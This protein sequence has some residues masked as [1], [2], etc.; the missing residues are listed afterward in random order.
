MLDE[1]EKAPLAGGAFSELPLHDGAGNSEIKPPRQN[2]QINQDPAPAEF[3]VEI[4]LALAASH[5]RTAAFFS[6]SHCQIRGGGRLSR[7]R[8]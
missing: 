1:I 5:W 4:V 3:D 7:T 6:Q 8:S 2:T